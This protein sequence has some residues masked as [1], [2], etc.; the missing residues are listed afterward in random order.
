MATRLVFG[1]RSTK[2][3]YHCALPRDVIMYV[4]VYEYDKVVQCIYILKS[5]YIW[6]YCKKYLQWFYSDYAVRWKVAQFNVKGTYT[7]DEND[8]VVGENI[9]LKFIN[10][11]TLSYCYLPSQKGVALLLNR[12]QCPLP[13]NAL[14]QHMIKRI[15]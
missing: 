8:P 1:V 4:C 13:K 12:D 11:F 7:L 14:C 10:F 5:C 2:K 15:F 9:F 6:M 3:H